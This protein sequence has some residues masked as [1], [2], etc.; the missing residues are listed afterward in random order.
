M[1]SG[2][3]PRLLTAALL[4]LCRPAAAQF[5]PAS[6]M[7]A[8]LMA[9]TSLI[10]GGRIY[11]SGGIS[12]GGGGF[13]S[14]NYYCAG[15]NPDGSL[16]AWLPASS[17]PEFY[18][19][20]LHASVSRA[21]RI[22]LLGGANVSGSKLTVYYADVTEDGTLSPWRQTRMMP[23]RV[24]AHA[25]A[26]HGDRVYVSG[27]ISRY[28]AWADV[29]SA[30][31]LESGALGA[32]RAERALPAPLFGHRMISAGGRLVVIGGSNSPDLYPG[33]QPA[34]PSSSVMGAAI[35][36]DGTLG[37]WEPL[38]GL[39]RPLLFHA[40]AATDKA[41]YVFGGF[42]GG[43]TDAVYFAPLAADGSTG[44]WQ[45][46]E[47][48]PEQLLAGSAITAGESLY[49]LGGGAAY[50]DSPR[51][52]VYHAKI[53]SELRALVKVT[54]ETINR[55][56]RGKWVSLLAALPEADAALIVPD[57]VRITAVNG[58]RAD[59]GRDPKF[60]PKFSS[61]EDEEFPGVEGLS[62]LKIKFDR[63]AISALLPEG[64]LSI[65]IEGALADGRRFSGT[66]VNRGISSRRNIASVMQERE[67]ERRGPEG[68]RVHL[69]RGSFKGNPELL[70][71]AAPEEEGSVPAAEKDSRG[72][73]MKARGMAAAGRPFEFGPHGMDFGE[74]VTISLPYDRAAAAPG[75]ALA[76]G[77]WN[78]G[79]GDWELLPSTVDEENGLV[80]ARTSHFSVYQVLAASPADVPAPDQSLAF[81]EVYAFPNPAVGKKPVIHAEVPSGDG[82]TVKIYTA[83]GR[84]A[85]EGR[86]SGGPWQVDDGAGPESAYEYE[87]REKLQAGVYY[88]TVEVSKGAQRIKKSGK[89]AVIR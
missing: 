41:V 43:V 77:Y 71:T 33:G 1:F 62:Y 13:L 75:R 88:F 31:F 70:L 56:A 66:A 22:Y 15:I 61:G 32:W 3:A 21:G 82:M 26:I 68:V 55:D 54:P 81:G 23:Q 6:H 79:R 42:D 18:G 85:D 60:S 57:S 29:Y 74:P 46:L 14:S 49:F 16:G 34:A 44:A 80:S 53:K 52:S 17:L 19:L 38:P 47:L 78:A 69:P 12:D 48:L 36:A 20:G 67:G 89:F 73:A 10:E 28:G 45:A 63:A 65:K 35:G 83:S 4:L 30:P 76:V 51:A 7:P 87:V 37:P 39:P 86:V 40:A 50:I 72:R 9:H 84:L 8:P 5:L 64:D 59:L 11:V 24:K 58:V 27:G 25:A 2:N